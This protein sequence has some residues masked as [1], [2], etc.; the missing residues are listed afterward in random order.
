MHT[1]WLA[2][3]CKTVCSK[4]M[5]GSVLQ[6]SFDDAVSDNMETFDMTVR[7]S[8]SIILEANRLTVSIKGLL[9]PAQLMHLPIC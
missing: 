9:H 6:E 3:T 2:V 8:L 5:S 4:I 1:A 7:L